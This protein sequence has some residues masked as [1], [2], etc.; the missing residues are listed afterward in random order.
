MSYGVAAAL[1]KAVYLRLVADEA[2]D[3]LVGGA[4]HDALPPGLPPPL[5]IALGPEKARERSDASGRGAE[6]DFSVVVVT[7][8]SGFTR[9]KEAAAAVS[10]ALLGAELTLERGRVVFL[11][12]LQARALRAGAGDERR[13]E[14]SFRARVEDI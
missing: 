2:L 10:D 1:Q 13:I 3:S 4:I 14:M 8:T 5:Y 6:H 9:A 12:F 11:D 7:E